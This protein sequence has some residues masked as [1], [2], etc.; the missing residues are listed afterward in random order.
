MMA[1]IEFTVGI[2]HYLSSMSWSSSSDLIE[3]LWWVVIDDR[4]EC[5]VPVGNRWQTDVVFQIL[6]SPPLMLTKLTIDKKCHQPPTILSTHCQETMNCRTNGTTST[7]SYRVF[8]SEWT[9]CQQSTRHPDAPVRENDIP[10]P[11]LTT[12]STRIVPL[13]FQWQQH[14]YDVTCEA[15]IFHTFTGTTYYR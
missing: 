1:Y 4:S 13:M 2:T 12:G 10:I 8:P 11:I 3:A 14:L 7:G 5:R 15:S 9:T 6:Q